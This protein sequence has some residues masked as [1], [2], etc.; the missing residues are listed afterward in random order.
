[1]ATWGKARCTS[2]TA[3]TARGRIAGPDKPPTAP[4]NFEV[5][6]SMSMAIPKT[7]L[8]SDSPSAPASSTDSAMAVIDV[9]FGDS[10]GHT[11]RRGKALLTA[12]TT[13]AA[14][15]LEWENMLSRSS[16]L[17]QE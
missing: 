5:R 3:R 7:V 8:M 12:P 15:D 11:G 16:R 2:C 14:A 13:C 17:G 1:M 6:D 10:L 4:A 9:T